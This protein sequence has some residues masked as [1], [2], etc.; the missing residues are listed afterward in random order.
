MKLKTG[1]MRKRPL[2]AI[3][4]AFSAALIAGPALAQSIDV[5]INTPEGQLLGTLEQAQGGAAALI[6]PGSGPTDQNGNQGQSLQ[7]DAY[8]LLAEALAEA[9]ITTL[10]INKRGVGG[11]AGDGNA[12]SLDVY[13]QDTAGW[14]TA[15]RTGT[16]ADCVWLIGHSEGAILALDA[17][18]HLPGICGLVLLASP[19]RPLGPVLLEQLRQQPQ[20]ADQ[21]A[22]ME[23]AIAAISEGRAPDLDALRPELAGLLA[24][25]A[26]AYMVELIRTDPATQIAALDMPIL[27][28]D[29][30]EDIQVPT[31][32]G[33]LLAAAN[34]S[35]TRITLS[36]MSH[37][38]KPVADSSIEANLATYGDPTLPLHP[39]LVP[40]IVAFIEGS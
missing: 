36:G 11:S 24:G 12:V 15:L 21:I 23:A 35:A 22:P 30:S 13:R 32:E 20:F 4:W 8:R 40:A 29:G 10:R 28:L 19:G 37:V 18:A 1:C 9:G 34:Q 33:D 27:I 31:A 38:L 16:G 25:P 5:A 39:E 17:A 2:C 3:A 7:T 26:G 14:T 6:L